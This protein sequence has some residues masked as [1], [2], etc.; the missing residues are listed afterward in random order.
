MPAATIAKDL[1]ALEQMRVSYRNP[2]F[3]I[4]MTFM[5]MFPVGLIVA[6]VSALLLRN[7]RFL[8]AAR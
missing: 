8:P 7:P 2:L 6:F 5:E 3:R 1:V 4:P